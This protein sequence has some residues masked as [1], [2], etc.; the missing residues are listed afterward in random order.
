MT[1]HFASLQS[2]LSLSPIGARSL[3]LFKV[4]VIDAP[5]SVD[6]YTQILS[7]YHPCSTVRAQITPCGRMMALLAHYVHI[8]LVLTPCADSPCSHTIG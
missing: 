1:L 8:P 4:P 7:H 3:K 6:S 5:P 2:H